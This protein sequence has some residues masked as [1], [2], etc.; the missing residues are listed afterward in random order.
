MQQLLIF[1]IHSGDDHDYCV[2][3]H[4]T[5]IHGGPYPIREVS[6]KSISMAMGI[7][8]P[9]F[10]LL[11]L[12]PWD[13]RGDRPQQTHADAPC[14]LPDQLGIYLS[15][16]I[17]LFLVS[18]FVVFAGNAHRM[19]RLMPSPFTRQ[20]T[21]RV[22]SSHT[23]GFEPHHH[24]EDAEAAEDKIQHASLVLP[25]P[26]SA[27]LGRQVGARTCKLFPDNILSCWEE[28][29]GSRRQKRL[30]FLGGSLLDIRDTAI[31]P[32]SVFVLISLYVTYT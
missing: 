31:F 8:H 2:Y 5:T 12:D 14:L 26:V 11:S 15:V 13:G 22:P 24:M 6:L 10:Q 3:Y 23:N 9:G 18:I 29:Q 28:Q 30:S 4:P 16:Y 25:H 17:P 7:R 1:G 32:L 21:R 20:P 19:R 27:F